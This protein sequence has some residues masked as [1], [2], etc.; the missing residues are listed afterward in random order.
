M[1]VYP[2]G[3]I[4]LWSGITPDEIV[5]HLGAPVHRSSRTK[6]SQARGMGREGKQTHA[7]MFEL[8]QPTSAHA[9]GEL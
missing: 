1:F 5:R 8:Q 6:R 3:D 4:C 7:Q 9:A 2:P